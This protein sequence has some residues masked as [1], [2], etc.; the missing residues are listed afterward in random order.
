MYDRSRMFRIDYQNQLLFR[1]HDEILRTFS[2]EKR[3]N[4]NTT[5][6]LQRVLQSHKFLSM[7][8]STLFQSFFL[9][10]IL[11]VFRIQNRISFIFFTFFFFVCF[12]WNVYSNDTTKR[13]GRATTVPWHS[14]HVL[15]NPR[16]ST[17]VSPISIKTGR[18]VASA[19][20]ASKK[21]STNSITSPVIQ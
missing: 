21:P 11:I 17:S 15:E 8:S 14:I 5:Y 12:Q 1:D 3:S 20:D 19:L 13:S 7:K 16:F 10:F 18:F 2:R 4:L 6:N 9:S